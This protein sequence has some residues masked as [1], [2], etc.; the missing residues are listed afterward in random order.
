MPVYKVIIKIM[1][2]KFNSEC[3][4]FH[5]YQDSEHPPLNSTHKKKTIAYGFGNPGP[6]LG[7]AQNVGG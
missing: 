5:Q 1:K 2:R 3:Q 4:Q 7:Q 6:G